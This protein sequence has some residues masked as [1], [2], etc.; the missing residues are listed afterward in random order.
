MIYG[1]ILQ[2]AY[3]AFDFSSELKKLKLPIDILDHMTIA[4]GEEWV[5]GFRK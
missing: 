5:G 2:I 1:D 4:F 3:G